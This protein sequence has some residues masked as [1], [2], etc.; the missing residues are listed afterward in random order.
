LASCICHQPTL[1]MLLFSKR[2]DR[3]KESATELIPYL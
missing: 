1:I 3:L 2:K